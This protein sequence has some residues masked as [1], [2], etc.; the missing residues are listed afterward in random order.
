[1][2]GL[3]RVFSLLV[4]GGV[5]VLSSI[6]G[7]CRCLEVNSASAAYKHAHAV[8]TGRVESMV[9]HSDDV[10]GLDVSFQV[11]QSWK[12]QLP[13]R[14]RIT[15]GTTC[16]FSFAPDGS[17]LLFLQETSDES[18]TTARCM[19]NRELAKADSF[20]KWIRENA[21]TGAAPRAPEEPAR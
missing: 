9:R 2:N 4:A 11:T 5:L 8:V 18:Y 19:G 6:A 13:A 3:W 17:Y 14:I 16:A 10:D 1:M 20:L 7:A 15:T 21:K 12:V